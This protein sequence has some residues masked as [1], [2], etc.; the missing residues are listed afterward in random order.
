VKL[1]T[2]F[3]A[4][5]A[6]TFAYAGSETRTLPKGIFGIRLNEVFVTGTDH[7]F[8]AEGTN[9]LTGD[10]HASNLTQQA[11]HAVGGEINKSPLS[12]D[13]YNG[14]VKA[15]QGSQLG[16]FG[17]NLAQSAIDSLDLGQMK[18]QVDPTVTVTTPTMLYGLTNRWTVGLV[19][20]FTHMRE[21]VTWKYIPGSS[22]SLVDGAAAAAHAVG[23]TAVPSSSQF[24]SLGQQALAQKGFKMQSEEKSFLADARLLQLFDLGHA[25]HLYFGAM[26][27]VN[28]PTGPKHDSNDLLDSGAFHHTFVEQEVT[29]VLNVTRNFRTYVSGSVRYNLPEKTDFRVP[30]SEFDL[31][32]DISQTETVKY[33]IGFGTM[34]EAGIKWRLLPR[35]EFSTGLLYTTKAAD[36]FSGSRNLRYDVLSAQYPYAASKA[37]VY[38]AG[39]LYD[40]LSHYKLGSVPFMVGLDYEQTVAGVQTPSIKLLMLSIATFF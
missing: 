14:I 36:K 24:I 31:D 7:Q 4:F 18:V 34:A 30:N 38:K 32:P 12:A 5:F 2:V 28:L 1:L 27:T 15:L 17:L 9:R 26:N 8:N 3:A 40:P 6:C 10:E 33:Q 29:A 37:T 13:I 35:F 11:V 23:I 25:G 16:Q 21:D 39:L 22:T 20:P 19:L